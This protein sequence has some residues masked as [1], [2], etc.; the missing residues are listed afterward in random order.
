MRLDYS[1]IDKVFSRFK[2][3]LDPDSARAKDQLYDVIAERMRQV[4]ACTIS[5][6][7]F[8]MPKCVKPKRDR[9]HECG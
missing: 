4:S 6:V 2:T 7:G 5:L 9:K 8:C 1:P 3:I